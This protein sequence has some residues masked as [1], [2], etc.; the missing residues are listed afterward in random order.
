MDP[1]EYT[2]CTSGSGHSIALVPCL[3]DPR[4]S[5]GFLGSCKWIEVLEVIVVSTRTG[6]GLSYN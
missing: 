1:T 3:F 2:P 4:D 6:G 5:E